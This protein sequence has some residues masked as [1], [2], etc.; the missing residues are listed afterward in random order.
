M[1][2][3]NNGSPVNSGAK[4]FL[5]VIALAVVFIFGY[6]TGRFPISSDSSNTSSQYDLAGAIGNFT[7]NVSTVLNLNSNDTSQIDPTLI[8][9]VLNVIQTQYVDA[10]VKKNDLY[11][12][13]IKGMVSG[14]GDL[15]TVFYTKEETDNYKKNLGGNF[16]GIGAELGYLDGR[17]IIKRLLTDS[18]AS[19]STLQIGDVIQKID[20]ENVKLNEDISIVVGKIR[21]VSGSSV[22]LSVT[23]S[24]LKN[25]KEVKITR[26]EIHSDSIEVKAEN[27]G[28][29]TMKINRFT[30]DTLEAFES[31][32]E[33]AITKTQKLNPKSIVL[34]LRGNPGGYLVGAYYVAS[35]FLKKGQIVLYVKDRTGISETYT[36]EK[37]GRL[38]DIPMIVLVDGGSAS[39]SEILAG[40]LRDNSRS[41]LM[42]VDTYGKGSAQT[43]MEPSDWGGFSL[44]LTV[45]K[46]L[47]PSKTELT[48]DKP[49]V[50]DIKVESSIDD[51]KNGVDNQKVEAIKYLLS[52]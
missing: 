6:F 35:D 27:D 51:F 32:W 26:A 36:V 44:H 50:P 29:V 40:S 16:E 43:V 22:T 9:K 11:V 47:M 3:N 4:I 1:V 46:W 7:N 15:P 2:D 13:A 8:N 10:N 20:G 48:K 25:A 33:S 19:K 34:D 41:K 31:N 37:D 30:E 21:G 12:G 23:D 14:L 42:G 28:V 49:L 39:A 18:P 45:Q 38:K 17:I 52:K 24:Q 5:V